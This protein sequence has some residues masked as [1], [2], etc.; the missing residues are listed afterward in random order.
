MYICGAQGCQGLSGGVNRVFRGVSGMREWA[1]ESREVS[2]STNGARV[3][4]VH[5]RL[6]H[7]DV[8]FWSRK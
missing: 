3:P 7:I 8:I 6:V 4:K 1:R 2:C 5:I